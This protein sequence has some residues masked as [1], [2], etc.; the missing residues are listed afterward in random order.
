MRKDFVYMLYS[1][2]YPYLPIF[3]AESLAEISKLF[4]VKIE[5]LYVN[6][7]NNK[8]VFKKSF[9]IEKVYLDN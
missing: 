3:C 6:H 2:K 8:H 9:T 4:G 7:K 5:N 1:V